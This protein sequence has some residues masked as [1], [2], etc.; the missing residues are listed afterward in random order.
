MRHIV[1]RGAKKQPPGSERPKLQKDDKPQAKANKR[2]AGQ[3][4]KILGKHYANKYRVQSRR[5]H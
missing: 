5:E 3:I 4:R 2:L 1:M